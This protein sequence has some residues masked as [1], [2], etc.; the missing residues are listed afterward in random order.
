MFWSTAVNQT[1][2]IG[3]L[4]LTS[5]LSGSIQAESIYPNH[6]IKLVVPYNA[7]GGT[8]VL[9]RIV[10]ASVSATLKQSVVVE[11]RTGASGM[12]GSDYVAKSIPDGYTLV[13]TAADT[14]TINP[15][16]YP[17][18][19][20]D[21]RKD[22]APIAQV[23]YLPYA[24][25]ISTKIQANNIKE[26]IEL[27]KSQPGKLTYASWGVGSSSQAAMEV[28]KVNSNINIMHVPFTGAAPAMAAVMGGQVDALF[29]PLSLAKPNADA[30]KV[31]ILGLGAPRR[32]AGA[33][34]IPTLIEQGVNIN[35]S[36][37]IG[38][39][40]P[41]KMPKNAIDIFSQAVSAA[42]KESKVIEALTKAGLEINYLNAEQFSQLLE[43]DYKMWGDTIKAAGI[44]ADY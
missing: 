10:A 36:P 40:G 11:N 7:G 25:V 9:T 2:S 19:A 33:P 16:V 18:I 4:G 24:L 27:A 22:F 30:G 26:F 28:L 3:L 32:F 21:A 44:K 31:K 13:M 15:H 5:L 1:I 37:W 42:T 23:G 17:K 43:V 14:H 39:L 29:V 8:D 35:T 12:I 41:A 38:I 20:Y 6:L 34:D